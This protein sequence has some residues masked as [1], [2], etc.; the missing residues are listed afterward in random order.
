MCIQ[1]QAGAHKNVGQFTHGYLSVDLK[2][3]NVCRG[4]LIR[5]KKI[6]SLTG[7]QFVNY[8]LEQRCK[9]IRNPGFVRIATKY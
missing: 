2:R 3:I 5:D 8:V 4:R 6:Q 9:T 1:S 7:L